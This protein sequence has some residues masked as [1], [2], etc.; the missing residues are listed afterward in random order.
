MA[1]IATKLEDI[2]DE[3]DQAVFMATVKLYFNGDFQAAL[4][5]YNQSAA[6]LEKAMLSKT[7]KQ[8][9]IEPKAE[10]RLTVKHQ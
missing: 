9:T 7:Y 5:H 10:I 4:D 8:S 3:R 2:G 6:E 1:K